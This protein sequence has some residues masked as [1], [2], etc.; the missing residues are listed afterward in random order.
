VTAEVRAHFYSNTI[1]FP[2]GEGL[3]PGASLSGHGSRHSRFTQ[4][5]GRVW[6]SPGSRCPRTSL[7]VPP[8]HPCQHYHCSLRLSSRL[9]P[10]SDHVRVKASR[11]EAGP[12]LAAVARVAHHHRRFRCLCSVGNV[13]LKYLFRNE[14]PRFMRKAGGHNL[15]ARYAVKSNLP[16]ISFATYTNVCQTY[17][18]PDGRGNALHYHLYK[19]CSDIYSHI[20]KGAAKVTRS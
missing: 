20:A 19:K 13:E 10:R 17:G 4:P 9:A 6:V 18:K 11:D 1:E 8:R 15:A 3:V 2:A 5:S 16:A 14:P 7:P 12:R